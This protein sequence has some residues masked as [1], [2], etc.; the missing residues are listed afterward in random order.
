[1]FEAPVTLRSMSYDSKYVSGTTWQQFEGKLV[2]TKNNVQFSSER[3][4]IYNTWWLSEIKAI[5]QQRENLLRWDLVLVRY[6]Y[7]SLDIEG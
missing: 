2:L 1:M 7:T 3:Y 6:Q 4:T 5:T